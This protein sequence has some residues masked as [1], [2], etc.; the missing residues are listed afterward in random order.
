MAEVSAKMVKELREMTGAGMMECKKALMEAEADME[1]AVDVLRTR[2]L[3]AAAKKAGRATNEGLIVAAVS[4]DMRTAALAEVNCETDFVSRNDVFGNYA[5]RVAAAVLESDPA[6]L[7]ALKQ[8]S[9][10][11]ISVDEMITEA[12]HTIGE[13]IQISRFVRRCVDTGAISSYIHAGGRLGVLVLYK[14]GKQET[15]GLEGFKTMA[16]DIAMQVAAANPA[17]VSR[18]DYS[19]EVIQHELSIYQAQAAESGKPQNIQAKMA[20]GRLEKFYQENTLL[21]QAFVKDPDITVKGLVAAQSKSLGDEIEV[22]AFE[23]FELGQG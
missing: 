3:A 17:T 21:E 4:D 5:A 13:N 14:L 23:R 8:A 1:K 22:I 19:E 12:I 2:G 11:G 6:D 16:K 18:T 15:A 10:G 20:E 9:A 7:E